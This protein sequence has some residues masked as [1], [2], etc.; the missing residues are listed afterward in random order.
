MNVELKLFSL[1]YFFYPP[2]HAGRFAHEFGTAL[3]DRFM[4]IHALTHPFA[5]MAQ[6]SSMM[7]S[8]V[9]EQFPHLRLA[10]VEAGCG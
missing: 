8:G 7:F 6:L 2:V 3:C 9:P 1:H 10:Y 5:K 4:D